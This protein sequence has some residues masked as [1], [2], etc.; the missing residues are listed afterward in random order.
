MSSMIKEFDMVLLNK[1]LPKYINSP[2]VVKSKIIDEYL[3]LCGVK[4]RNTAIKRF[5]RGWRRGMG[6]RGYGNKLG[7][8]PKYGSLEIELVRSIYF[9]SNFICAERLHPVIPIYIEQ[10]RNNDI[11]F[12]FKYSK[13]SIDKVL[14]ISLG[15]LKKIIS[16]FERPLKKRYFKSRMMIYREIPVVVNS[17]SR[18]KDDITSCGVDFVEHKGD[19]S[20]GRYAITLT[21]VNYYSQWIS[22]VSALGKDLEAIHSM[23]ECLNLTNPLFKHK[24]ISKFHQDNDKALLSYLYHKYAKS[25]NNIAISRTRSYHSNDNCLVEQKNGDKVRNIV[26]YWRYDSEYE[27]GVLNKIWEIADLIDNFFI[28]SFKIIDKIRNKDGKVVKKVYDTPKTPYQRIM[29]C[30]EAPEIL[31]NELTN[32]YNSLNLVSLQKNLRELLD[33]LFEMNPIKKRKNKSQKNIN[34][35]ELLC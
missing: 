31:K 6:R 29:E 33:E 7:R 23:F 20:S 1:Y 35:Q 19:S 21:L 10:L 34:Y 17:Y 16:K 22:R 3:S 32:I 30:R 18:E 9:I 27:V 14:K 15:S 11:N 4:K 28:P 5:E 26:G 13:E 8:P 12:E 24:I 25:H 2:K